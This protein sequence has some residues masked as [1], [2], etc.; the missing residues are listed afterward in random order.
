MSNIENSENLAREVIKVG[1]NDSISP[2]IEKMF[3]EDS[4]SSS[5]RSV[6]SE[7][8]QGNTLA[9]TA[10]V[11]VASVAQTSTKISYDNLSIL[12]AIPLNPKFPKTVYARVTAFGFTTKDILDSTDPHMDEDND[13]EDFS[14]APKTK[15]NCLGILF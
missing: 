3:E 14:N 8:I 1:S 5:G 9:I 2:S 15:N 10:D 4:N 12:V 7:R 11:F 6:G 13:S